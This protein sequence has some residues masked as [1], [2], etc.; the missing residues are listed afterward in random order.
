M[1]FRTSKNLKQNNLML[2]YLYCVAYEILLAS[3][4][5]HAMKNIF[6]VHVFAGEMFRPFTDYETYQFELS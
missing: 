1:L 2:V 5:Q 6:A 4:S 3:W